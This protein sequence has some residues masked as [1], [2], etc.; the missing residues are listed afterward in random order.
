MSSG[1]LIVTCEIL[2]H[3][4]RRQRL[5]DG[6]DLRRE[7]DV[8]GVDLEVPRFDA[9]QVEDVV[10]QAQQRLPVAVMISRYLR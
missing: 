4:Q 1:S 5:D 6:V 3:R 10:D 8:V 2:R 9:R 7:I